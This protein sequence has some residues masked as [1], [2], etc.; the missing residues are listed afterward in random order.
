MLVQ[1]PSKTTILHY[2]D[3]DGEA[4]LLS[5]AHGVCC[6]IGGGASTTNADALSCRLIGGGVH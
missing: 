5:R 2:D 4:A 6:P 3:G 1:K